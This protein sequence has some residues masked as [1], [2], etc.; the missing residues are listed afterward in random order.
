MYVNAYKT[1]QNKNLK[2]CNKRLSNKYIKMT[3]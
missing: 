1:R 3:L 2:I